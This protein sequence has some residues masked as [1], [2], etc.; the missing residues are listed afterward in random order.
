MCRS[1]SSKKNKK[2]TIFDQE[3]KIRSCEGEEYKN[4]F[5]STRL[6]KYTSVKH[7]NLTR[8]FYCSFPK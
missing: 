7:L 4:R 1:T 3:N 5:V 6:I 8:I 2:P